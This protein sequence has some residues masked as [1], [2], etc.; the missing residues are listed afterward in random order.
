[1]KKDTCHVLMNKVSNI[2]NIDYGRVWLVLDL[3]L[4]NFQ[5]TGCCSSN[6]EDAYSLPVFTKFWYNK[7][8]IFII[9]VFVS[10]GG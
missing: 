3:D 8:I 4:I 2:Y 9:I 6:S 5:C 1:M 10:L 7:Q